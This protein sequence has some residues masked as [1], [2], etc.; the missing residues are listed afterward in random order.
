VKFFRK[1]LEESITIPS[2]PKDDMAEA[3]VVK[4]LIANRSAKEVQSIMDHDEV[5]FYAIRKYCKD[6]GMIFHKDEFRDVIYQATPIINHFKD[7]YKRKRPVEV[8]KTLNTLPSKTNK[9]PSYPSGHAVQSRLVARYV[10]GK[11][12]EHEAELIKAGNEC[13]YG[14]VLAGFHYPSDYDAGNLLGEKMYVF[15]NKADYKKE[16]E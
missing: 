8:D 3:Q 1:G 12:P 10:A 7:K 14:R 6:N 9:T 2:P 13:G 15:M 16:N 11:F 5:P 4:R